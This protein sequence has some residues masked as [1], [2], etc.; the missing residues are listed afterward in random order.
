MGKN[1]YGYTDEQLKKLQKTKELSLRA[2]V[3][4]RE[5]SARINR[6][7]EEVLLKLRRVKEKYNIG[8]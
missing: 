4:L 3:V 6:E 7:K 1:K 8:D 2:G 5:Y